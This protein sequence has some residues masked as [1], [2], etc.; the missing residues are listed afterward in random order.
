MLITA[1][2]KFTT[3]DFPGKLACVIFTGGCNMRCGFCHN[4]EFVLPEKLEVMKKSAIPF[5]TVMNFL[6]ARL[7]MLE[8]VVIC[9]GEPTVQPDLI[10]RIREIRGLGYEIKLDTNGLNPGVLRKILSEGLVDYVSM[11]LKMPINYS[12]QLVGIT[13]PENVLE[14]SVELI[15]TS[16]IRYEF[17]TTVIPGIHNERVLAEMGEQI[18]GAEK[19]ALQGFRNEKTLSPVFE[20]VSNADRSYLE[21][22]ADSIKSYAREVVVR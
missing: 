17:R 22:L 7:G 14:E 21:L 3:I 19:W 9:G 4:S 13:V 20:H 5:E 10:D 2:T 8:G 16:G 18:L 11:D 15:K 1:L 6:K 12:K